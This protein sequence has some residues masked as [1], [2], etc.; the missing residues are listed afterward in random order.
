MFVETAPQSI[1]RIA[2]F[3]PTSRLPA[4]SKEAVGKRGVTPG[5]SIT[6]VIGWNPMAAPLVTTTLAEK[7]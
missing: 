6:S 7:T 5:S 3:A 1:A 2:A 4:T